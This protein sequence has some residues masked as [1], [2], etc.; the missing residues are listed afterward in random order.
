MTRYRLVAGINFILGFLE[1]AT[2]AGL[3]LFVIPRLGELNSQLGIKGPGLGTVYG[4]LG[5]LSLMGIVNLLLARKLWQESVGKDRYLRYAIIF[6]G[7][8]FL[9]GGLLTSFVSFKL[10]SPYYLWLGGVY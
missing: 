10:N 4:A 5:L 3:V 7:V 9:L 1:I 2:P 8:S 6:I